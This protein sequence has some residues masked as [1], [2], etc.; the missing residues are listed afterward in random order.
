VCDGQ[1]KA[2]LVVEVTD[3]NQRFVIEVVETEMAHF[4]NKAGD[5]ELR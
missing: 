5:R 4:T 2:N 3:K 1:L